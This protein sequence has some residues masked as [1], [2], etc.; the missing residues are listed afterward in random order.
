[1]EREANIPQPEQ[2]PATRETPQQL[3][4]SGFFEKLRKKAKRSPEVAAPRNREQ[5][6]VAP[7]A[8]APQ[9]ERRKFGKNILQ[10]FLG[11]KRET[12]TPIVPTEAFEVA[13]T[14]LNPEATPVY[15]RATRMRRFARVVI[16]RVMGEA[17]QESGRA[18]R[19]GE[20]SPVD[21]EPLMEAA[22]DL[23]EAT[24]DLTGT[25]HDAREASAETVMYSRSEGGYDH[26]GGSEYTEPRHA[27]LTVE[28]TAAERIDD[29]LRR[30]EQDAEVSK[31]ATLAAVGLGVIAVLVTGTEYFSS[32]KRDK[33]IRRDMKKQFKRQE[34]AVN[35]QRR[36]FSRLRESDSGDLDRNQRQN[37]YDKLSTFTHK[38]AERTREVS[39]ELQEVIAQGGSVAVAP[40]RAGQQQAERTTWQPRQP[41]RAAI[42]EQAPL[43][44]VE[45]AD[46]V[47]HAPGQQTGNAGTGFFGGGGGGIASGTGPS[48]LNPPKTIDPN[49]REAR[50]LEAL[51]KAEQARLQQNAW[52]Y[53]AALVLAMIALVIVTVVLG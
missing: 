21:T 47:E 15:D 44:R 32:R 35:E 3:E 10:L 18:R 30:L 31:T 41:E 17:A 43:M 12:P 53:S 25:I 36:E 39:R 13:P 1:M 40:E 33:E 27:E 37:Y 24:N 5:A 8:E 26:S 14:P 51:R 4:R 20:Q 50:Q 38:Q 48:D 19:Q 6:E 49:S 7:Q 45:T 2:P 46:T 9:P 42:P 22:N 28:Q 34:K 29:R 23:R 52:L 16:A 11:E